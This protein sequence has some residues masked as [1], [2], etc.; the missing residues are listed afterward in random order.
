M[1][2][3]KKEKK[4]VLPK[5]E[6]VKK[7]NV[8]G[9]EILAKFT[10]S[11]ENLFE[12]L[13]K[14]SFLE[15]A[16]EKKGIVAINVESRDIKKKPYLFSVVYLQKTKIKLL[17]TLTPGMS[18]KKRRLDMLRYFFE[19]MSLVENL[20]EVDTQMLHQLLE[21]AVRGLSE[22]VTLDYER[23]FSEHDALKSEVDRLSSINDR[24]NVSNKKLSKENYDLKLKLD[25]SKLQLKTERRYS[26]D[27]LTSKL[28]SWLNEHK[29]Q[30]NIADFA[31]VYKVKD[32]RVEFMLN[33][34][35]Q[36]GYIE[37]K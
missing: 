4:P 18:P 25:E 12:A 5:K 17:Y 28:I 16:E 19:I 9:F 27:V 31:K 26:D 21:N 22:Y 14:L 23:M 36:K 3:G 7:P 24:L 10:S 15:I 2:F 6:V 1:V 29:G 11:K 13:S 8:D 35:V 33:K 37:S 20:Y 30:I 32:N 34:L